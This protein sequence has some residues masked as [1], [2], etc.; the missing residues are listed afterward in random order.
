MKSMKTFNASVAGLLV[1][2]F[3]LGACT[4]PEEYTARTEEEINNVQ[5]K[6]LKKLGLALGA[7][8]RTI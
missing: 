5:E 3:I 7:E 4:A 6:T 1:A 2:V 8:L